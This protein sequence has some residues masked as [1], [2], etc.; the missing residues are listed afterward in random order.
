VPE[1]LRLVALMSELLLHVLLH[2]LIE[3]TATS[4]QPSLARR[5]SRAGT[6]GSAS[7]GLT[8]FDDLTGLFEDLPL[9]GNTPLNN[10]PL[11]CSTLHYHLESSPTGTSRESF[12]QLAQIV[13]KTNTVLLDF[14]LFVCDELSQFRKGLLKIDFVSGEV[15]R[16]TL[17]KTIP[18]IL[19]VFCS[20]P[21]DHSSL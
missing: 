8:L 16:R 9:L 1:D 4:N 15:L 19:V 17:S 6:F 13:L 10:W 2:L 5:A 7:R 12:A 11:Q 20:N 14:N 3:E 18:G 21:G